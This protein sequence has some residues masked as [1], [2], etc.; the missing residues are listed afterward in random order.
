MNPKRIVIDGKVYNSVDEMPEDV[1]RQYEQAL[2][3]FKDQNE[4]GAPDP[5]ENTNMLADNNRNGVP[6]ILEN[7][8]GGSLFM[9]S[10]KILMDG[11]EFNSIDDLPP[12]A[13]AKYER[14]MGMLD[15]NKNGM[16]DFLEG[17]IR[18]QSD[19]TPVTATF[20]APPAAPQSRPLTP[21]ESPTITPDTTNGWMLGLLAAFILFL[22]ALGAVGVWYFFLR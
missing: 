10:I 13:R 8:A 19:A 1:R 17:S 6:D 18:V 4:R 21:V 9:N 16:P 11:K 15:A 2:R 12:E 14:A 3:A 20:Q 22:C 7:T 5:F